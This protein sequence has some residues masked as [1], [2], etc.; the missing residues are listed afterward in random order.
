MEFPIKLTNGDLILFES[1][2]IL[3]YLARKYRKLGNLFGSNIKEEAI[4]DNWIEAEGQN[5]YPAIMPL[6]YE[7]VFN[8]FKD[9]NAIPNQDIVNESLQKFNDILDVY[10]KRLEGREYIALDHFTIADL[11]YVPYSACLVKAGLLSPFVSHPNV[12]AWLNRLYD[13]ESWKK[14]TS[15]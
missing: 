14:V 9:P 2:T 13:R 8:K 7:L 6:L 10:E 1:R 5:Y 12:N 3:K 4:I 15:S 11:S